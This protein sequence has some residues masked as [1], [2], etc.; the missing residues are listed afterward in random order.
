MGCR[1]LG[2][3][4]PGRYSRSGDDLSLIDQA[5]IAKDMSL[6]II[7][8]PLRGTC[9]GCCLGLG[10]LI[11]PLPW[12]GLPSS[13]LLGLPGGHGFQVSVMVDAVVSCG[14]VPLETGMF[15]VI[16]PKQMIFPAVPETV[17]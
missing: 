5:V 15:G 7:L 10:L 16:V 11:C 3:I 9:R 1:S 4:N 13:R 14:V 8:D 17:V 12:R 6:G 2:R